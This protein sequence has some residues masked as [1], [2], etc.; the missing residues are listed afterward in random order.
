MAEVFTHKDAD[1]D[2]LE[3]TD[4]GPEAAVVVAVTGSTRERVGVH[5]AKDDAPRVALELLRAAGI[6]PATPT[7][8]A[9]GKAVT[10]GPAHIADIVAEL[11]DYVATAPSAAR[12]KRR[13]ELTCELA[14]QAGQYRHAVGPLQQAIDRIIDLEEA[15]K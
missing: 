4:Y 9:W 12:A 8:R 7:E 5:V 3:M 2:R 11:A 1:G 10:G 15:A 14:P 13:D 6:A